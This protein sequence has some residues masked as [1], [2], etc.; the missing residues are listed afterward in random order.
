M[1]AG[2]SQLFNLPQRLMDEA[3]IRHTDNPH[4]EFANS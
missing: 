2:A 1:I 3:L 4:R